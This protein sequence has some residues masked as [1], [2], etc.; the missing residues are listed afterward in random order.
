MTI[1]ISINFG[2]VPEPLMKPCLTEKFPIS[3]HKATD[4]SH[5]RLTCC[6]G[7]PDLLP[8]SGHG[9]KCLRQYRIYHLVMLRMADLMQD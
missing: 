1:F 4:I 5:C 7:S 6:Y 3:F 2:F 8:F 9:N